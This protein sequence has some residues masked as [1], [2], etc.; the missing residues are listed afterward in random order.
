[1]CYQSSGSFSV[2]WRGDAHL[3]PSSLN[4][5]LSELIVLRLIWPSSGTFQHHHHLISGDTSAPTFAAATLSGISDM[6]HLNTP[7]NTK[8]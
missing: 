7:V 8:A 2:I 6:L 5:E 3:S 4:P 1:M